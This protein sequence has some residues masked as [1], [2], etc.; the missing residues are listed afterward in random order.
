MGMHRSIDDHT[1][2][3][4]ILTIDYS[5]NFTTMP[6]LTKEHIAMFV[7]KPIHIQIMVRLWI[8]Q[9]LRFIIKE[10]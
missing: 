10:N 8:Y 4:L 6:L 9:L 2:Y 1:P 7:V 5:K 3:N